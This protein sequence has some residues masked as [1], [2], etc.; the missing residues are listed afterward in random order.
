ML[1]MEN[2][3]LNKELEVMF[4]PLYLLDN[5]EIFGI[6]GAPSREEFG[7]LFKKQDKR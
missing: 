1:L 7:K 2:I 4:G 5:Q 3:A 6:E